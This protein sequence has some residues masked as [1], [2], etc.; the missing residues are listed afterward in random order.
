MKI[1]VYICV[2]NIKANTGIIHIVMKY[3]MAIWQCL[4]V[5][6]SICRLLLVAEGFLISLNTVLFLLLQYQP[7]TFSEWGIKKWMKTKISRSSAYYGDIISLVGK[8][9]WTFF[10]CLK[11][12]TTQHNF[13]WDFT[14]DW[15]VFRSTNETVLLQKFTG[16]VFPP[17]TEKAYD[18]HLSVEFMYVTLIS[19]L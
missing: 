17:T 11:C 8:G 4:L 13:P 7:H 10:S 6:G 3:V 16:E 5:N 18:N 15:F 12:T 2:Y 14:L 19:F 9:L 1:Y